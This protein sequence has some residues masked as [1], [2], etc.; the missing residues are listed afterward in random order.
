MVE[1]SKEILIRKNQE[2]LRAIQDKQR[3]IIDIEGEKNDEIN[4]LRQDSSDMNQQ[5]NHLNYIIN[6]LKSELSDK[7]N[8]I[9]RSINDN[10]GELNALKQQ[11][12][13]KKQ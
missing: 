13:M 2:L 1:E 9:G 3:I 10:D 8:L 6:K 4:K 12:Q 5:L 11:L 7:D